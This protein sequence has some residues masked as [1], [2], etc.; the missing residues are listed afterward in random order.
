MP[1][2]FNT[3]NRINHQMK[4]VLC[5]SFVFLSL[6]A[7]ANAVDLSKPFICPDI[8]PNTITFSNHTLR[9]GGFKYDVYVENTSSIDTI[10][11]TQFLIK[12]QH[13]LIELSQ[14]TRTG[15]ISISMMKL[16]TPYELTQPGSDFERYK[17]SETVTFD[18]SESYN[19]NANLKGN[20]QG[21][22]NI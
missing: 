13:T 10:T 6:S 16:N 12:D 15:E 8:S 2:L 22:K 18:I 21:C 9:I 19:R 4:K 11:N 14:I 20:G 17:I 3:P 5:F 7:S 1:Y